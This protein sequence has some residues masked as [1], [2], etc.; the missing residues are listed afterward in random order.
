MLDL[1]RRFGR[2]AYRDLRIELGEA[3]EIINEL[4][5]LV[6]EL[7]GPDVEWE[8]IDADLLLRLTCVEDALDEADDRLARRWRSA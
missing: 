3:N 5:I 8:S 7:A 2:R 6:A 4:V 1:R